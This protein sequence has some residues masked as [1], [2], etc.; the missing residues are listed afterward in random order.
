MSSFFKGIRRA[1]GPVES[2]QSRDAYINSDPTY[3]IGCNEIEVG[4]LKLLAEIDL[5]IGGDIKT[6]TNEN[7][8]L[9]ARALRANSPNPLS[10][11]EI[12][13]L[14]LIQQRAFSDA[15]NKMRAS[16]MVI[17]E[18]RKYFLTNYAAALI[19]GLSNLRNDL[20]KYSESVGS[21][22]FAPSVRNNSS[23]RGDLS[24]TM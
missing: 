18:G 1:Q 11:R 4:N 7:V 2:Q 8:I 12:M 24:Q 19:M 5:D 20:E 3:N 13:D 10:A 23:I 15:I 9:I 21:D 16:G 22:L 14:T 6:L 17:A